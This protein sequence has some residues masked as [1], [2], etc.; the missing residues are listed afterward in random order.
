MPM[1][2]EQQRREKERQDRI[3][4]LR[5]VISNGSRATR[6]KCGQIHGR[7][8]RLLKKGSAKKTIEAQERRCLWPLGGLCRACDHHAGGL[9][10]VSS[11]R[12]AGA[13]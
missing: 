6:K 9:S 2:G 11:F 5:N 13:S 4:E 7:G 1:P 8:T 12:R 3:K 10:T